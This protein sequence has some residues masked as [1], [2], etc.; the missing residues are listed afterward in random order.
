LLRGL[1]REVLAQDE[2]EYIVTRNPENGLVSGILFHY[3]AEVKTSP[4]PAYNDSQAAEDLLMVGS[5]RLKKLLL[6]GLLSGAPFK[7]EKLSPGGPGDAKSL[8]RRLGSPSMLSH[9]MTRELTEYAMNLQV[10]FVNADPN[11]V[12]IIE[13][14]M[15][16]WSLIALSQLEVEL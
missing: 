14:E 3:P 9:V 13:D 7:I 12:L 1:G 2:N 5:P 6:T 10:F 15:N 4:P 8:Y 11:G 16:P